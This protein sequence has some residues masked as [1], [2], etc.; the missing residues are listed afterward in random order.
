MLKRV[1]P[2]ILTLILGSGL[3]FLLT[4]V[5]T[6]LVAPVVIIKREHSGTCNFRSRRHYSEQYQRRTL[7]DF[8]D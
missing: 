1:L 7:P 3:S 2:F 5:N 4:P 8:N 6:D